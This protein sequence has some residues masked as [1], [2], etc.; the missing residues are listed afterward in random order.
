MSSNPGVPA[1][2][3]DVA[4]EARASTHQ[5][6]VTS[7]AAV[8]S[9]VSRLSEDARTYQGDRRRSSLRSFVYGAFNPRRRRI[10]REEDRDHTFLDWHPTQLLVACT[11]I[12]ALSVADGLLTVHLLQN[13]AQELNPLMAFLISNDPI[14]FAL[15]K[16][17]L[18]I[19]GV[20][21]LVLT[22]H[23]Q[24]FRL[25]KASSVLY[26]FL[27]VH[28]VLVSYQTTLVLVPV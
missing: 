1:V 5:Q 18:T 21:T 26:F 27:F 9:D 24:L 10:R 15:A 28:V 3:R 12:M 4:D 16:I 22:A 20:V 14:L 13:G 2:V 23:M 6:N 17:A 7:G 8:Q 25:V 11:M 19:I